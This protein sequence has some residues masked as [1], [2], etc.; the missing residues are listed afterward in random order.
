MK[1]SDLKPGDKAV[2]IN[3][4]TAG[5]V[6][7]RLFDMGIVKGTRFKV[8]RKAP[9]GDPVE[10][11]LRGFML[12]LRVNEADCITVEKTGEMGDGR[13]MGHGGGKGKGFGGGFRR[14][15]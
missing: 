9:L 11:K 8:I 6:S 1:M 10:I 12:A 14:R 5:E 2:V 4:E 7:Q 15:E 3:V 13:P